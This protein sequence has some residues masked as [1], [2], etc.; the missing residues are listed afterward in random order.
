MGAGRPTDVR[1]EDRPLSP[2]PPP[3]PSHKGRNAL[4]VLAILVMV[5]GPAA[6]VAKHKYDVWAAKPEQVYSR[7]VKA[8]ADVGGNTTKTLVAGGHSV[9]TMFFQGRSEADIDKA[10]EFEDLPEDLAAATKL[11]AVRDLCPEYLPKLKK[12]S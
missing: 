12:L 3:G 5:L 2:L 6:L 7:H 10:M 4:I 1:E 8:H 11:Y 9:C